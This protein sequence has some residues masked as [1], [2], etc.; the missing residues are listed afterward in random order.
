MSFTGFVILLRLLLKERNQQKLYKERLDVSQNYLNDHI[1][2]LDNL[3][4]MMLSLHQYS[5]NLGKNANW[6][7]LYQTI[8]QNA[9]KITNSDSGSLMMLDDTTQQLRIVAALGLPED[10]VKNTVIRI[11]EG[12]A[13]RVAESG[14]PIFV[15]DIEQ[16]QR[17][18]RL[19]NVKYSTKSF[20]S[21]PLKTQN[22]VLG[23][24]NIS[25]KNIN[26]EFEQREQRLLSILADQSAITLENIELYN[27]LQKFYWDMV[28]TL[29]R[30]ID[31]KDSYT[32]EHA[33]RAVRYA[34]AIAEEMNLPR[35]ITKDLEYAALMHDIGKIG[36]EER[37]LKKP[38]DLS[39]HEREVI[40]QH[41]RI[42]NRILAP[43]PFL[44]NVAATILYHHEW[45][46]GQGY[47][48]GL[49]GEE[50]P[51]GSR[52]IAI[53]D[54]YDAMTSDRPYRKSLSK[55]TAI[56][57]IKKGAGNQFDP[58]VV[59]AFLRVL[60]KENSNKNNIK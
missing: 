52:I 19:S 55:E 13:G 48:E 35:E 30:A 32:R 36:I 46:N 40:K 54:A 14:K 8:L 28:Q 5:V 45:Y 38:E 9:C 42:G 4:T 22:R 7:E 11:G 20:L 31:A 33:D 50:I 60:V 15:E 49:S 18:L 24:I 10:V 51:L 29:A 59:N 44:I 47:L 1:N 53:I 27:N 2:S 16:D 21:V 34:R 41:P 23:V 56:E 26:K 37:I 6:D 43:V 57:E 12:I 58:N 25:A 39:E 3:I 17:F